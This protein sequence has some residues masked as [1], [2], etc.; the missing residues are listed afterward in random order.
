MPSHAATHTATHTATHCNTHCNRQVDIADAHHTLQHMP[1]HA[2]THTATNT[3]THTA[4]GKST[5][6][7]HIAHK[8]LAVPEHLDVLMVE[9]VCMSEGEGEGVAR[10]CGCAR[11]H[12][13]VCVFAS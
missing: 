6:L 2:A 11:V 3:A 9:Q 13:C 1:S 7:M 8:R 4:T 12:M 5:L 10:L